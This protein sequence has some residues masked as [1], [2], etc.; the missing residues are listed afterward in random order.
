MAL[1]PVAAVM[2]PAAAGIG[3]ISRH[4]RRAGLLVPPLMLS[5]GLT[6]E[7]YVSTVAVGA[8]RDAPRAPAAYPLGGMVSAHPRF[9]GALTVA[10]PRRQRDRRE[11]PRAHPGHRRAS[12]SSS[13]PSA[14]PRPSR[15]AG[16][17][18]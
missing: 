6:G 1:A 13:A 3:A 17:A 10:I 4:V 11:A 7:G 2:A 18:R 16:V 8:G 14:S 12:G 5:A 9:A 15:L